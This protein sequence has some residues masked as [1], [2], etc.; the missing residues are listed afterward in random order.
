[1]GPMLAAKSGFGVRADPDRGPGAAP[2]RRRAPRAERGAMTTLAPTDT[3]D[4]S[5]TAASAVPSRRTLVGLSLGFLVLFAVGLLTRR[6]PRLRL[7]RDG[8]KEFDVSQPMLQLGM[9][10]GI[11]TGA[12]LVFFGAALMAALRNRA[13]S[14]AADVAVLGFVL[15]LSVACWVVSGA[16]DAVA[17]AVDPGTPV[18]SR[19]SRSSTWPTSRP[20]AGSS[21]SYTGVGVAAYVGRSLPTWLCASRSCSGSRAAR[22]RRLRVVHAVPDLGRRRRGHGAA[23]PEVTPA[24]GPSPRRGSG[25]VVRPS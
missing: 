11:F 20:D 19:R 25:P 24:A 5:A 13:R 22:H 15:G 16:R 17:H 9:A 14:W 1:M 10:V 4:S 7:T 21:A 23:R 18:R 8:H 12:L 6:T 3:T 2:T